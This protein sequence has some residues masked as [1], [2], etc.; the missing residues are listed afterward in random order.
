MTYMIIKDAPG[1]AQVVGDILFTYLTGDSSV[2]FEL[3]IAS[4]QNISMA[5]DGVRVYGPGVRIITTSEGKAYDVCIIEQPLQSHTR[6]P[7]GD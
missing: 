7:I 4:V 2:K 6:G 3:G 1:L 5:G